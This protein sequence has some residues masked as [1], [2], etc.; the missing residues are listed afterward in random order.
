MTTTPINKGQFLLES[1]DRIAAFEQ[2]RGH[3]CEA[4][5]AENRRLW[6]H[7]PKSQIVSNYPLHVD[8][9][10]ASICNLRCPMC[11]T[12]SPDFR[13]HVNAKL[14][15]TALFKKLIDECGKGGVYSVRLSFRGESFLHPDIV[16]C[17][18]YAKDAGIKEVSTLT[19]C[20]RMD[21][22]MFKEMMEAGL[23]WL[24]VSA[25]GVGEVYEKIRRPAKFDRLVEKLTNFKRIREEAGYQKPVIKVQ[26]I[27]PAI[28]DNPD[29]FYQIFSSITDEVAANPLIDFMQDKQSPKIPE[30]TCPQPFQRL[31]IGADGLC[32]MCANDEH[33]TVVIGDANVQSIHEIWHSAKMTEVRQ[34][35]IAHEG[36][37][38]LGPCTQ[39]Y[40]PL[41]TREVTIKVGD[42]EVTAQKYV[43]GAETVAS[44]LTPER[45]RREGLDV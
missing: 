30:F 31:V 45:W 40:L 15:D 27:L 36:C 12:I 13:K 11:Y 24:T 10:L 5:Y 43:K 33:G 34:I 20:E 8:L 28:E 26:S 16:E 17:A 2:R 18:R 21:E 37:E 1:A 42:R 14:M 23:D 3:G 44:L 38:K 29:E 9:E 22:A 32:M 6:A 35:Q 25:D 7:L 4:D 39:C 41:E 19:N